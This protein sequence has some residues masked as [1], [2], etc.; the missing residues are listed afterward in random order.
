MIENWIWNSVCSV[1]VNSSSPNM[2][3]L[4]RFNDETLHEYTIYIDEVK[5]KGVTITI[6]ENHEATA[7]R[8]QSGPTE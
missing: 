6:H 4:D 2:L 1:I 7:T 8:R 5:K 3:I